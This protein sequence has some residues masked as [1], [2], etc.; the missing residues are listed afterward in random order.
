MG[1]RIYARTTNMEKKI[2]L[3]ITDDHPLVRTALKSMLEDYTGIQ[4][5]A[6]AGN[7]KELLEILKKNIKPDV[8]LLDIEMPVMGGRETLDLVCKRF[9]EVKVIMV[10]MHNEMSYMAGFIA[11]GARAYVPK[12]ADNETLVRAIRDVH[13]RGHYFDEAA[14][15]AMLRDLQKEKSIN[16]VYDALA[17][18]KRETEIMKELCQGK[19][20]KVIA[21]LCN[22]STATVNFHRANIYRKTR[23][24]NL[25]DLVKYGIKNGV[26]D[27]N[28]QF[29][30]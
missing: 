17:L 21:E 9:P 28:P 10:S 1:K 6:E 14:S 23:S 8:V 13:R 26:I 16:P 22:I 2:N 20:N 3:V 30:G 25:S 11:M 5:I 7:G 29:V 18:S 24:H 19:T 4:I 27:W 12:S 15:V